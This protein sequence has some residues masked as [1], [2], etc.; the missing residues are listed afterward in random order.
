MF[1]FL[2]SQ[3]LLT[4]F[5][6][7]LM[8]K[9]IK[10]AYRLARGYQ[11]KDILDAGGFPSEHTTLVVATFLATG[12]ETG[13]DPVFS[14]ITLVF[15]LIVI[16]DATHVRLQSELHARVLNKLPEV[17]SIIKKPLENSLG[18]TWIEVLGGSAVALAVNL[19]S[20]CI[21]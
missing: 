2:S 12:F 11:A 3:I 10:T 4:I 8:A 9:V 18:H 19:L 14:S 13:W 21:F 7:W 15:A 6:S 5:A 17:K 20:Y 1:D 16:Y